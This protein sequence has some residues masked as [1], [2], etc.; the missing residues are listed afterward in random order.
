MF[1]R[2]L[3]ASLAARRPRLLLALLAVALGVAVATALATLSLQ[4]GDDLARTLRAAGPNFVVRPAGAEW[5]VDLAGAD[6]RPARAGVS[7]PADALERLQASFWRNALLAAAPELSAAATFDGTPATLLGTW[8]TRELPGRDGPWTVGVR[9]LRPT[10]T[11]AGRWPRE[12]AD[13]VL[14]GRDLA[15]R[16]DLHPGQ[17]VEVVVEGRARRLRVAGV[18]TAGGLEDGRAWAPL[19]VVQALAGRPG[20]TDRVWLSALVKPGPRGPAPDPARDPAGFERYMCTPY[21]DNVARDLAAQLRG[22]EVLPLSEVVAGEAQVV[23]R[24]NFMLLLLALAALAAATLGLLAT[25]TAAVVERRVE[26]GL[27]RSLGATSRQLAT[28]LLGETALVSLAG[29]AAGWL[30]GSLAAALVRGRTFGEGSMIE[31]ILLPLALALALAVAALGTLGP[32][33]VALRLDPAT[34]LRDR[35]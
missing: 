26:L 2:Y 9:G 24:L 1:A 35:P 30:L 8:F 7:L 19:T 22:A 16:L 14:L 5:P 23:G 28:L 27:L 29:G 15:A 34:V 11:L 4:V 25:T 12:D 31:P 3:A 33:R 10:W 18:V 32:M 17:R 6:F 21:P 13:E 20:Q